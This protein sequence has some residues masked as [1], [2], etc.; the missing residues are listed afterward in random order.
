[1]SWQRRL[2]GIK[3]DSWKVPHALKCSVRPPGLRLLTAIPQRA[4]DHLKT[5]YSSSR[6]IVRRNHSSADKSKLRARL[7]TSN[8]IDALAAFSGCVFRKQ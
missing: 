1:M 6:S 5:L 4:H 3:R 8:R 7:S 2:C